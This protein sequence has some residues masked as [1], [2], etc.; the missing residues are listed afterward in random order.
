M[1]EEEA[2]MTPAPV[3]IPS[4][5]RMTATLEGTLSTRTHA[6]GDRFTARV[7]EDVLAEDGMVLV[8][9]GTRLEGLVAESRASSDSRSE[10]LMVLVFDAVVLNGRKIPVVASVVEAEMESAAAASGTRTAAT[11]ATGAAA[12]AVVG[13]ILGRDNRSTAVGAAAGAAVGTGIALTTRDG[14]AT[15]QDGS[16]LVVRVDE[17]VYLSGR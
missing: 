7:R 4:G 5:V 13:R 14:H 3:M 12:G 11:I 9:R 1:D 10:A 16:R 8:P 17:A 6:A 15:L 2:P